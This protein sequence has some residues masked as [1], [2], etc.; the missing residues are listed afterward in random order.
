[1]VMEGFLNLRLTPWLRRR[2]TRSLAII[3][4]V[5][6]IHFAG[7]AKVY[8]LLIFSQ[9]ILSLQLP[10][11][12]LPLIRFTSDKQRMGSFANRPWMNLLAIFAAILILVMNFWLAMQTIGSWLGD[13][14]GI[15]GGLLI[16]A[17]AG[18]AAL[19][20]YLVL[21]PFLAKTAAPAEAINTMPPAEVLVQELTPPQYNTILVPLDHSRSDRQA[22]RHAAALARQTN[23][24]LYLLHV[25]EGVTSLIYG[26]ESSTSEVT[27]GGRYLHQVSESLAKTGVD[28]TVE[29]RHG[30]SASD[31][32]VAF[33]RQ[34]Q[35][36][37]IVMAG[38]G[39]GPVGDLLYGQTIERVRHALKIPIFV[40]Q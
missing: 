18:L 31:A 38:H 29:I 16:V 17:F 32:I 33:A 12:I 9:V 10:F 15:S 26:P 11:A 4:A 27:A 35:P 8:Q 6:T 1:M 3:P 37:L 5:A 22:L 28:A 24:R 39:H 21:E 13:Q 36:D 25:E 40:V 30:S 7:D 34:L 14:K 23:A 19:L 2:A 20:V